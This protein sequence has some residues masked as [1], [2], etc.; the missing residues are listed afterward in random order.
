MLHGLIATNCT[1]MMR[2]QFL[3]AEYQKNTILKTFLLFTNFLYTYTHNWPLQPFNQDYC[4]AS[5]TSPVVCANFICEWRDLYFLHWLRITDFW[6]TFHGNY[7]YSQSFCQKSARRKSLKKYLFHI[8]LC[9]RCLTIS[10]HNIC[11][12]TAISDLR[13]F[14]SYL[15]LMVFSFLQRRCHPLTSCIKKLLTSPIR[16]WSFIWEGQKTNIRKSTAVFST[17]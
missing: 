2:K 15:N 3:T 1:R 12:T 9:W 11:W 16:M 8:P 17:Y 6:E 5:H 14:L 10:Q 4:L 7:I 13:F